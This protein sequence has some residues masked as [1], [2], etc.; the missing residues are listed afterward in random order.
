MDSRLVHKSC[1]KCG[2]DK[3]LTEFYKHPQMAD[4]HLGKCKEC[5]RRDVVSNRKGKLEHYRDYDKRRQQDNESRRLD[6]SKRGAKW[7]VRYPIARAAHVAVDNAVR[8]GRLVKTSCI[9]CSNTRNVQGHHQDYSK[10]LHVVW[11]C[12]P[13]HSRHH[14]RFGSAHGL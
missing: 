4:G 5:T 13:C 12:A 9:Q 14:A 7:R 6:A 10:P 8:D 11:L 3:S 2:V 1:F